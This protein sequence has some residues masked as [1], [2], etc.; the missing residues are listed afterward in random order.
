MDSKR[1]GKLR[2]K[3]RRSFTFRSEG[4]GENKAGRGYK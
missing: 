4:G 2:R 1:N 3:K